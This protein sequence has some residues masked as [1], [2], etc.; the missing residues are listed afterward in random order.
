MRKWQD[1]AAPDDP[2]SWLAVGGMWPT[3]R[4][5]YETADISSPATVTGPGVT[6]NAAHAFAFGAS[7]TTALQEY[8]SMNVAGSMLKTYSWDGTTLTERSAIAAVSIPR[9]EIAMARYGDTAI[10]A[11]GV[12][13]QKLRSA[14]FGAN[15]ADIAGSP[16]QQCMLAVQSNALLTFSH[17]SAAWAASDV[18]DITN[19]STGESASGTLNTRPGNFTAAVS[20]GNDVLAFKPGS[21]HRFTYVGAIVKWQIQT[22][23]IGTGVPDR[24]YLA[25][26]NQPTQDWA[27]ATNHGVAF[28]G[29][30]GFVYLFDGASEPT[31]L[32]PL[33][34]IPVETIRGV[35]VYDP[36]NDMLCIAPSNGSSATGTALT[37]GGSSTFTSLYYYYS[38]KTDQWGTGFGSAG[39]LQATTGQSD[40]SGV[41]R[42]GYYSRFDTASSKPVF[43]NAVDVISGTIKRN[44][45]I[46][47]ATPCSCFLQTMK[48]GR[49]D[50]KTSF[51]RLTPLL[52]RRTDLGAGTA[53]AHISIF[54]EREDVNAQ[55]GRDVTE[56]PTRKRFDLLAGPN[57]DNFATLRVTWTGLDV[58]V[59]DFLVA[60]IDAGAN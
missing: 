12:S 10:L 8:V 59:D 50:T 26:T 46:A 58:E 43:W 33:T 6:L 20:C 57:T 19:W 24:R 27:V 52:R 44:A 34:T 54:R 3:M 37:E 13:G 56:A 1:L 31:C 21:I 16:A 25:V 30:N 47:P 29:G 32:N 38:F 35:F 51:N 7:L 11:V 36:T 4:G 9:G 22:A 55:A 41:L 5:T 18:G 15:F 53:V 49:M 60:S 28:Y 2:G 23:W 39:E 42:G 45:P 40:A 14:T 48:I 17:I